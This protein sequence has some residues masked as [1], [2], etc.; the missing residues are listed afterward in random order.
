M[1]FC[2]R[3]HS[4]SL[5]FCT[6]LPGI[7]MCNYY[8]RVKNN[9]LV[10]SKCKYLLRVNSQMNNCTLCSI[11]SVVFTIP[12]NQTV[13]AAAI[14]MLAPVPLITQTFEL[15]IIFLPKF[16]SYPH[17]PIVRTT[18]S[19]HSAEN[20]LSQKQIYLLDRFPQD[21]LKFCRL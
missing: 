14:F 21:H 20:N 10:F 18:P 4:Y 15:A 2:V 8:V 17:I 3:A 16:Q 11:V 1:V 12:R 13:D 5:I 19:I 7:F 9:T 6:T